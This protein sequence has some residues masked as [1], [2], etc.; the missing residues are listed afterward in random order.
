MGEV[1]PMIADTSRTLAQQ[2]T[3]RE[4][5]LVSSVTAVTRLRYRAVW[6][7]KQLFILPINCHP[8]RQS[9][10]A[11]LEGDRDRILACLKHSTV[12]R[13]VLSPELPVP[14]LL[15]WAELGQ[16]SGLP[17]YIQGIR[18]SRTHSVLKLSIMRSF[19]L[20]GSAILLLLIGPGILL[21]ALRLLVLSNCVF[22]REWHIGANGKLFRLVRFAM[23]SATAAELKNYR[24]QN[25]RVANLPSLINVLRGE[26]TL[27][28]ETL[29]VGDNSKIKKT[30]W[31]AM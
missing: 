25:Y 15:F 28:A 27:L 13:L 20:V 6:R 1:K 8:F 2:Q 22:E 24:V 12:R 16:I 7:S 4:R 31:T 30:T 9:V 21:I 29:P 5:E 18:R 14:E 17:I 26:M 23:P 19:D 10:S 11:V 3:R